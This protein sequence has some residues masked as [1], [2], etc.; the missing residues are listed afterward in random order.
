MQRVL[1]HVVLAA[2]ATSAA[3]C[4]ATAP[5]FN[6]TTSDC[7][8]GDANLSNGLGGSYCALGV[9]TC[10][11]ATLCYDHFSG[12]VCGGDRPCYDRESRTC[13]PWQA[14]CAPRASS[15]FEFCPSSIDAQL[16]NT[17]RLETTTDGLSTG[18]IIGIVAG[19]IFGVAFC[20]G[21]VLGCVKELRRKSDV[22]RPSNM[23]A[24]AGS[25]LTE[26]AQ[27]PS[28]L[29]SPSSPQLYRYSYSPEPRSADSSRTCTPVAQAPVEPPALYSKTYTAATDTTSTF[30]DGLA[31]IFNLDTLHVKRITAPLLRRSELGRGG[32]GVVYLADLGGKSVAV[33]TMLAHG[34]RDR[35]QSFLDEIELAAQLKSEYIVTCL[36]AAWS[37]PCDIQLVLEYMPG[38]DLC[39]YLPSRPA[40]ATRLQYAVDIMRGLVYLHKRSLMHRDL[41][42]RNVLLTQDFAHAKLTD[43][44]VA[45]TV[46]DHTM[47]AKMGT[48]HWMAPEVLRGDRDYNMAADIFSLGVIFTEL[49]T[50]K[51]PYW[52]LRTRDGAWTLP[53]YE[54]LGRIATGTL[55]PSLSPECPSWFRNLGLE[56]LA[57]EPTHRPTLQTLLPAFETALHSAYDASET[58]S[59]LPQ[60]STKRDDVS[61]MP[62]NATKY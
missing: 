35:I 10:Q 49:E 13:G 26:L 20:S 46:D 16:D 27:A 33:K 43:L 40:W 21:F 61:T 51:K 45:R 28:V 8:S 4:P 60:N 48:C 17:R 22:S 29:S 42:T 9:G 59:A 53:E 18:A 23:W 52:E 31:S 3:V 41:K 30:D 12:C 19:S 32:Y 62:R 15:S 25:P 47:T 37:S 2:A 39:D 55:R 54:R 7:R 58:M 34:D 56:C 5:C 14:E 50:C 1:A 36:G 11:N 6:A 38:G 24:E 57:L 44:G